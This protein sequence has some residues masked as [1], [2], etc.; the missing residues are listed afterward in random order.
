MKRPRFIAAASLSFLAVGV[1]PAATATAA[2]RPP[3]TLTSL[4]FHL[5]V[6][7]ADQRETCLV[8]AD[9]RVPRGVT[10]SRP[11][12]AAVMMT[13][14]FGGS[15]NDGGTGS[16]GARFAEQG[17]LELS[18]SSLGFGGSGCDITIADP[19]YDGQVG[20]QLISFL[21]GKKGLAT[22]TDG[23][24]F[25]VAGLVRLDAKAHD[26]KH[27]DFDPR[28]GTIGG[29][30]GGQQQFAIA[31]I[32]PRL[33]TMIP[34]ETWN[35]LDHALTPNNAV[36]GPALSGAQP[37]IFKVGWESIFVALG[38]GYKVANPADLATTT[39]CGDWQ[40]W[41]CQSYAE[42]STL[43]Y[44][45]AVSRAHFRHWSVAN[46]IA[47]IRIPVLLAQGE[48]DSLFTLGEA[49]QNYR[50]LRAQ[51][52]PV[53]MLFQ[54]WGHSNSTP[55]P[56]E[57]T[58]GTSTPNSA[59]LYDSVEGTIFSDWF[60]HWLLD[61]PT[62]LGPALR[63]FQADR[64]VTPSSTASAA[65]AHRAAAAAYASSPTYPVAGSLRLYLSGGSSLIRSR[66]EV[67]QG[68]TTFLATGSGAATNGAETVAGDS[69][70]QFDTP[71]TFAAWQTP[72]L[73]TGVD[74]VGIPQLTVKLD[75]P[76]I[77]AIQSS[78]PTTHLQVFA[79]VY[80]VAPDGTT[81][82]IHNMV[83]A[84]RVPDINRPVT[85][86]LAGAAHDF[87]KGHAIKLVLASS[88]ATYKGLGVAGP[89]TVS[90]TLNGGDVLSL[91]TRSL[92]VAAPSRNGDVANPVPSAGGT[93]STSSLAST[94]LSTS[95]V[96]FG[97]LAMLLG[98]L[99]R[100]WRA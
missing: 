41:V 66:A 78:D 35:D 48:N 68:S 73:T 14:G 5:T 62:D 21:G 3:F 40:P 47:K 26:G 7:P 71:G 45:S 87:A 22:T 58:S 59:N 34:E 64:Y 89:V 93:R 33:D 97:G 37:G 36:Q 46:Y 15:K 84:T 85:W 19:N 60:A 54:S 51:G 55:V 23:K 16:L 42:Q 100:R 81:S 86:N 11:A 6:G 96:G 95:V 43:G 9:V 2:P 29:S 67:K 91:P 90:P 80:D 72:P 99:L 94:G 28:V 4:T 70:P 20:S 1:A 44:P 56:G 74:L 52:V 88:D 32:D 92:T 39:T 49:A 79:K 38:L 75:A 63:Y 82:L 10:T 77:A 18:Y 50:T 69:S 76:H 8:V 83:S 24:A 65:S 25:D 17:Y 30:S 13:N 12:R 53:R 98:L 61:K 27:H 57:L 31:G